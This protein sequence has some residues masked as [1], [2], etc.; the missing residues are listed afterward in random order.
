MPNNIFARVFNPEKGIFVTDELQLTDND[1]N[2]EAIHQ[3][4]A[5]QSDGFIVNTSAFNEITNQYYGFSVNHQGLIQEEV[6]FIANGA[7]LFW[8]SPH[9]PSILLKIN[10]S[11]Q[12]RLWEND[13]VYVPAVSHCNILS[14]PAVVNVGLPEAVEFLS[15]GNL[16]IAHPS[17]PTVGANVIPAVL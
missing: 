12:N 11:E 2:A 10:Q 1:M 15:L 4:F 14:V 16:T 8:R 17:V 3:I 6:G 13:I 9:E 7:E 5:T